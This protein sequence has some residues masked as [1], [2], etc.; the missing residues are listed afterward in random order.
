MTCHLYHDDI[1]QGHKLPQVHPCLIGPN[2]AAVRLNGVDT[3]GDNFTF[4]LGNLYSNIPKL[5]LNITLSSDG[6]LEVIDVSPSVVGTA[7]VRVCLSESQ[8]SAAHVSHRLIE[9]LKVEV[10]LTE[11]RNGSSAA[12]TES[13][14]LRF[15]NRQSQP[16][17]MRFQPTPIKPTSSSSTLPPRRK[18]LPYW[19]IYLIV[20]GIITLLSSVI[21]LILY[22]C[23]TFKAGL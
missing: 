10:I 11:T 14:D 9:L 16:F 5:Q 2:T 22:N 13:L 19:Q 21:G 12:Q 20:L 7:K 1:S 15:M 6:R 18:G 23:C 3:E 8:F 4:S 17:R